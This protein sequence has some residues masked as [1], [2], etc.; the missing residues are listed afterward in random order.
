V[1]ARIAK[2]ELQDKKLMLFA[3]CLVVARAGKIVT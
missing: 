1:I 3:F 2:Q